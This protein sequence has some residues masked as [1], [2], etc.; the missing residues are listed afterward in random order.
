MLPRRP[1]RDRAAAPLVVAVL[2]LVLLV[3]LLFFLA[4]VMVLTRV[5][6]GLDHMGAVPFVG[7]GGLFLWLVVAVVVLTLLYR[8]S[9]EDEGEAP[10]SDP[11]LEELRRAYARGEVDDEEFDRRRER[12]ERE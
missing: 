7:F 12:L 6:G 5:S 10:G 4:A 1:T 3:A 9:G 8:A 2:G 11:A